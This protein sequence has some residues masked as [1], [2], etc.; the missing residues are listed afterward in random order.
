M[1]PKVAILSHFLDAIWEVQKS[2]CRAIFRLLPPTIDKEPQKQNLASHM[3]VRFYQ[4]F[5][6][7]GKTRTYDLR[8]MSPTSCQ[9][10]HPAMFYYSILTLICFVNCFSIFSPILYIFSHLEFSFRTN[11]SHI[12]KFQRLLPSLKIN[13][14]FQ[15]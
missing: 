7:G 10:L 12:C 9:L 8:V 6:C 11:L 13:P 15:L 1:C 2:W 3:P 5:G 4:I 14:R